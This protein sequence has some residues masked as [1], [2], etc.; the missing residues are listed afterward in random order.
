MSSLLLWIASDRPCCL[1]SGGLVPGVP[2]CPKSTLSA[3]V[4]PQFLWMGR[5][6]WNWTGK[7]SGSL[8]APGSILAALGSLN[9]PLAV[10]LRSRSC[11]SCC[12]TSLPACLHVEAAGVQL[13]CAGGGYVPLSSATELLQAASN[14]IY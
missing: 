10:A 9:C 5:R 7:A 13:S 2:S 6:S 3:I 4:S 8:A 1:P 11:P 12:R 14:L